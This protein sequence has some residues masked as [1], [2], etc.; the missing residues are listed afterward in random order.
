MY[1]KKKKATIRSLLA[2][3][4]LV[5]ILLQTVLMIDID[6]ILFGSNDNWG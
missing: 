6:S 4:V 1:K 5:A 3:D 2:H